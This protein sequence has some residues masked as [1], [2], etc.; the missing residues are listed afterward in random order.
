MLKYDYVL[1]SFFPFFVPPAH[2]SHPPYVHADRA[3]PHSLLATKNEE[4]DLSMMIIRTL[5]LS[6]RVRVGAGVGGGELHQ[7][8]GENQKNA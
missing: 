1:T 3:G 7:L 8:G 4:G 6:M 5:L 2:P